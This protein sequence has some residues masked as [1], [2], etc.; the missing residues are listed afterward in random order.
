M[1]ITYGIIKDEMY[2]TITKYNDL[3]AYIKCEPDPIKNG[4]RRHLPTPPEED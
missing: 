1:K 4:W 2:P 3:V